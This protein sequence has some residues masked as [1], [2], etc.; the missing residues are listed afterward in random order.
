MI[1][2]SG[3]AL[4]RR[5]RFQVSHQNKNPSFLPDFIGR[6]VALMYVLLIPISWQ[7]GNT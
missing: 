1:Y 5:N 7:K 3:I 6:E 4:N 2:F